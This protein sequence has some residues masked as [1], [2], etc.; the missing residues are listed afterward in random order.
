MRKGN[1]CFW[2]ELSA[3]E[4]VDEEDHFS[5]EHHATSKKFFVKK[6]KDILVNS[7]RKQSNEILINPLWER[8][9]IVNDAPDKQNWLLDQYREYSLPIELGGSVAVTF[10]LLNFLEEQENQNLYSHLWSLS[11]KPHLITIIYL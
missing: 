2:V 8:W 9:Y 1:S 4:I 5:S 6:K 7:S 11:W 10:D 3:N